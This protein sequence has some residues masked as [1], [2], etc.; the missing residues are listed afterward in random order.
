MPQAVQFK[1]KKQ[2]P[3]AD[4]NIS[5]RLLGFRLLF[6]AAILI[7][8]GRTML[9]DFVDW[10]DTVLIIRNPNIKHPTLKGL[11]HEWNPYDPATFYMYDP[12]VYTTW[13]TISHGAQYSTPTC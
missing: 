9:N 1:S 4:Q 12:L 8:Y 7:V 6:L 5:R 13:W 2:P 10:D 11:L 3:T